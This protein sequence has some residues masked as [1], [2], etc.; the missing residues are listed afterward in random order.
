MEHLPEELSVGELFEYHRKVAG[1]HDLLERL[2]V[3]WVAAQLGARLKWCSN[4]EI[5]DLLSLV[6]DVFGLFSPEYA[7]CEHARRR[8]LKSSAGTP[9]RDWR[10]IRDAGVELLNT[11]A[12]LFRSGIPHIL[13]PFQRDRFA[14][15]GFLVPQLTYARGCLLRAGFRGS[16]SAGTVLLD[17]QTNRPIRLVEATQEK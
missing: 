4:A 5:G 9:R 15:N 2:K 3:L 10:V 8:L 1:S 6:Q 12:A 7:V 13:L 14:S 17:D 11:E 16:P